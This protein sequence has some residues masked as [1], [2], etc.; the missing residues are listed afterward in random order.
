MGEFVSVQMQAEDARDPL[1]AGCDATISWKILARSL[2]ID[3][4]SIAPTSR[5][6]RCAYRMVQLQARSL[7][8]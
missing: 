1:D 5:V 3:C 7:A 6:E 2:M 8:R 4:V